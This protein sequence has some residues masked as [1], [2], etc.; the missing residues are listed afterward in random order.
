MYEKY[1]QDRNEED[2]INLLNDGVSK[3][4]PEGLILIDGLKFLY[5]AIYEGIM[6]ETYSDNRISELWISNSLNNDILIDNL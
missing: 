3:F 5:R 2:F 6:I 1:Y 4:F